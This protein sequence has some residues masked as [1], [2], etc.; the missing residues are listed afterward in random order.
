M[1][2][3][4]IGFIALGA[5]VILSALW[6]LPSQAQPKVLM[7]ISEGFYAPEYYEPRKIL[8]SINAEITVAGKY[9]DLI[10]P[11][12]RNTEY[13]P[14]QADITFDKVNPNEYDVIVFSGGNGAWEDFFPNEDVH[15]ILTT[16]MKQN[17]IVGD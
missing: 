8:E 16:A 6:P 11:D 1:K 15:K 10:K 4:L 2:S 12:R 17:K 14:V 13:E 7:L 5:L 9:D 3:K